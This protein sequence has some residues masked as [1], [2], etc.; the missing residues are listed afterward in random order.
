MV[1]MLKVITHEV[2]VVHLKGQ[3]LMLV[4]VRP[5]VFQ[6]VAVPEKPTVKAGEKKRRPVLHKARKVPEYDKDMEP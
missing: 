6:Q 5:G 1:D 3:P 2:Q 4:E